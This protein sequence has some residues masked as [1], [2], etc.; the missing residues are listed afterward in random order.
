MPPDEGFWAKLWRG[1][2]GFGRF[3]QRYGDAVLAAGAAVV[4]TVLGLAGSLHG[5]HL[6]EAT[7]G[8]FGVISFVLI[9]ER[10]MREGGFDRLE[11]QLSGVKT[12]ADAAKESAEEAR[13]TVNSTNVAVVG[14]THGAQDLIRV[15]SGEA[16]YEVLAATFSWEL[17]DTEGREAIGRTVKDLRFIADRVFCIYE[18]HTPSGRIGGHEVW[19]TVT[20]RPR[21][22][23]PVMHEEFPGPGDK[24]YRLIS[25]E[26]FLNR[27]ER[28]QLESRSKILDSFFGR[29]EWVRVDVEIA[30]DRIAIEIIWPPGSGLETTDIEREGHPIR[31]LV[32]DLEDLPDGRRRLF[33]HIE[34]PIKG[35]EIYVTWRWPGLAQISTPTE[36]T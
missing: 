26:G 8:L 27:G 23:L 2:K 31:N 36:S 15:L 20:G 9:R 16:P 17:L 1:I 30:A 34:S 13:K 7:L 32:D 19:G 22:R 33:V 12:D 11:E 3:C 25:L 18:Q 24:R 21:T 4:L 35:E 10:W 28:M 6:T 5:D 14:A 29:R